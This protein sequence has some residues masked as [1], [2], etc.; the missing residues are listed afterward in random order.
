MALNNWVSGEEVDAADFNAENTEFLNLIGAAAAI[1]FGFPNF[2]G[3]SR[4]LAF[5]TDGENNVSIGGAGQTCVVA[6]RV[7]DNITPQVFA[8]PPNTTAE[9]R[10]DII[11]ATFNE[12]GAVH[13]FT[14][15]QRNPDGTVTAGV[16]FYQ[17]AHDMTWEYVQGGAFPGGAYAAILQVTVPPSGGG[18][19]EPADLVLL[20]PTL[21]QALAS[22]LFPGPGIAVSPTSPYTISNTGVLSLQTLAGAISLIAGTG[23]AIAV[24]GQSITIGNTGVGVM[25]LTS[26][27]NSIAIVTGAG[28]AVTLEGMTLNGLKG[29]VTAGSPD[30]SVGVEVVGQELQFT[31]T[32]NR[33]YGGGVTT[34]E[35][36]HAIITVPFQIIGGT[37]NVQQSSGGTDAYVLF[38]AGDLSDFAG[39]VIGFYGLNLYN[40]SL[41]GPG[42]GI[43]YTII[44]TST[45]AT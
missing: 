22:A 11:Y 8:I 38:V 3:T 43:M 21:A 26:P 37:A 45:P 29:P 20:L 36:G 23:V 35:N 25:S 17:T 39:G 30:N 28:G 16:T 12:D 24:Q 2:Q 44:T 7:C 40:N 5:S 34:D 42:L 31:I 33:V 10:V 32:A 15:N 19:V 4:G 14:R 1:Y 6:G 13:P 41:I 18:P 27:D 9:S